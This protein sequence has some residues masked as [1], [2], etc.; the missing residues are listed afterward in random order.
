MATKEAQ[1]L[2]TPVGLAKYP[3][4][5]RPDAGNEK[6][7]PLDPTYKVNLVFPAS[8]LAAESLLGTI[9]KAADD[10]YA[11]AVKAHPDKRVRKAEL[12]M[13]RS[14]GDDTFVL[15]A[16]LVE[17]REYTEKSTGQR[18]S[19]KQAPQ[20][21]DAN[22]K[23]WDLHT[24]IW[25]DS[26]IR[27]QVEVIPYYTGA[28]GAGVSLRLKNV[29]VIEAVNGTKQASPFGAI[30]PAAVESDGDVPF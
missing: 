27:V 22:G 12:P 30:D 11:A 2:F 8:S 15:K 7:G 6:T 18:K 25:S 19:F 23:P 3:Y 26:K 21:V 1:L 14:S 20:I 17:T 16:K 4:L 5:T 9:E 10:A 13:Y 28:V 29:Q 24:D